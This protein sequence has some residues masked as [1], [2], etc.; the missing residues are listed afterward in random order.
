MSTRTLIFWFSPIA[1]LAILTACTPTLSK[2][3]ANRDHI[4]T[5]RGVPIQA[6][7][8]L[9][10]EQLLKKQGLPSVTIVAFESK[11]VIWAEAFG[12]ANLAQN[13]PATLET[14]YTTGST[15]K[16]IIATAI[17]QLVEA[18]IIDL[19]DPINSH[20]SEPIA[21][22]SDQGRPLTIRHMLAH[23]SGL[24]NARKD[25][26]TDIW[27]RRNTSNLR[28]QISQ[29]R[30]VTDPGEKFDYCNVCF[31]LFTDMIQ[32]VTGQ[33]LESYLRDKILIPVG[34]Q[35]T[36]PL[37]PDATMIEMMALPY[38]QI[39]GHPYPVPQK[40]LDTWQ[41]GDTYLR[42]LDMAAFL[43]F[44]L[45]GG[46]VSDE[47]ILSE[48]YVRMMRDPQFGGEITLGFSSAFEEDV[49]VL[50]W[51]GGIR[52][53]SAIYELEPTNGIGVYIVSNSNNSHHHLHDIALRIRDMMRNE[54]EPYEYEIKEVDHIEPITTSRE[55][56]VA[57]TGT[58]VIEGA[59]VELKIHFLNNGLALTNPEGKRIRLVML[60]DKDA[61]LIATGERV[62]FNIDETGNI[63]SLILKS[64]TSSFVARKTIRKEK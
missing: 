39:G 47:K 33:S 46:Q 51:D 55:H 14:V 24:E 27:S 1:F 56:L 20:L 3:D 31:L 6:D 36:A 40:F 42:P 60:D 53:G 32:N 22:F 62:R 59:G 48:K 49:Q 9:R 29:L 34:S 10:I 13:A 2:P 61:A 63:S 5:Q 41:A 38:E 37:Y 50:G 4:V 35:Y 43:Q 64:G 52:G 15:F 7:M 54:D 19:D 23:R 28:N 17:M 11:E 12:Y 30:S 57:Y 8:S 16:V 44:H 58:Y 21:D 18:G 25:V 26:A 45:D